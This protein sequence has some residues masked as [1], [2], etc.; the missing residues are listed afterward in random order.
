MRAGWSAL[1]VSMALVACAPKPAVEGPRSL[2]HGAS[3][4]KGSGELRIEYQYEPLGPRDLALHVDMSEVGGAE[5]GDVEVAV[6]VDGFEVVDGELRWTSHVPP[7]STDRHTLRLK[8][9]HEG[10]ASLTI[11]SRHVAAGET[12]STTTVMFRVHEE[13]DIRPCNSTDE[14]CTEL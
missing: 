10:V 3:I 1:T 5:V 4:F 14:E 11:S 13:E 12:V 2:G 7:A 8:A 9:E 6:S